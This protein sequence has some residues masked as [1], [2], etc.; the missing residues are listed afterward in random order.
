MSKP[1]VVRILTTRSCRWTLRLIVAL[2]EKAIPFELVNVLENG[3]KAPWFLASTPFGK[4][5]VLQYGARTLPESLI[6][7]EYIEEAFGGRA[8]LP[9]DPMERAW[10]RI[11]MRFCDD[12][13]IKALSNLVRAAEGSHRTQAIAALVDEG[14]RL[15]TYRAAGLTPSDASAPA[16]H[17]ALAEAAEQGRRVS[18]FW[19]GDRLTLP[20]IS[21]HT[22]FEAL[23]RTGVTVCDCFLAA[24]PHLARWRE[25]LLASGA[26][27]MAARELDSLGD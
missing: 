23:E 26:F 9:R 12:T 3:V 19:H 21:Y 17:A 27:E 22:F 6:I 20:D 24:C 14:R 25:A 16:A 1:A 8:L 11:W 5:P 13:L 4:T 15:E 2:H 18:P 10:A 7:C